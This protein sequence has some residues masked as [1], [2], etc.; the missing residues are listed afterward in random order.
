MELT[1]K[2]FFFY[3]KSDLTKEPIDKVLAYDYLG[4]L[5]YFSERKKMDRV[6]FLEIYIVVEKDGSK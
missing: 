2:P 1:F 4:A 6:K 3:A 5:H